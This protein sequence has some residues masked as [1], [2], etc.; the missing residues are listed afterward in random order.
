[1]V[2][3]TKYFIG[4]KDTLITLHIMLPKISRYRKS[5][6]ETKYMSFLIKDDKLLEKNYKIWNQASSSVKKVF[7]SNP[8]Y[9]ETKNIYRL[10]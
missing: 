2:K 4:Y 1:M 9:N 3:K 10:K 6:D 8:V 7:D 5:F